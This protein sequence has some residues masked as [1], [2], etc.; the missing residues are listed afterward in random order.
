MDKT[1]ASNRR[2]RYDY[3]ILQTYE[4]GL[5][6][7]GAE[8]KSLR[9]GRCSLGDSYAAP[10]NGEIYLHNLHIPRYDKSSADALNPRRRRK[11]LFN[12][13][14]INRIIRAV[15]QK[16][17]TL[18]PLKIYFSGPYAKVEIAL[19]RG[20]AK[21]DKRAKIREKDEDKQNWER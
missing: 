16:G 14:E 15:E 4:A 8:V 20:K 10:D 2:A 3:E 11:L 9:G 1:V 21:Y 6:L 5:V 17:V 7:A 18:I 19:A 12:R 13:G